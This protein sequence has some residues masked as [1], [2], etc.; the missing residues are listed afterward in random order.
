MDYRFLSRF[1]PRCFP[2]QLEQDGRGAELG[3]A[4][5]GGA[6]QAGGT[7][8]ASLLARPPGLHPVPSEGCTRGLS[9][10]FSDPAGLAI[11]G[12]GVRQAPRDGPSWWGAT[13]R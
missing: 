3:S 11:G 6:G 4:G 12:S 9:A 5:A 1:Q 13:E 10:A 7:G 2:S 8:S